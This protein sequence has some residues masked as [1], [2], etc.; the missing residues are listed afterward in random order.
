MA[1]DFI[2][3]S[4]SPGKSTLKISAPGYPPVESEVEVLSGQTTEQTFQ[5]GGG[6]SLSGLVLDAETK[7][8]IEAFEVKVVP[9]DG[10]GKG[11]PIEGT[12]KKNETKKGSFLLSSLPS[13]RVTVEISRAAG[14]SDKEKEMDPESGKI[15]RVPVYSDKSEEVEITAG[16]TTEQTFLLERRGSVAGRVT[17][18]GK[19][20]EGVNVSVEMTDGKTKNS[21]SART[22]ED[23]YYKVGKLNIGKCTILAALQHRCGFKEGTLVEIYDRAQVEVEAG[24]E[25]RQ[26]FDFKGTASI[27][28]SFR[29][30]NRDLFWHVYVLKG[31]SSEYNSV[32]AQDN[33][34]LQAVALNLQNGDRYEIQFLP[35]GTYTLI[36]RCCKEYTGDTPVSEKSQTVT[37]TEGQSL[38][39]NFDLP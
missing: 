25:V 19:V 18:N 13:G 3:A 12:V 23:G 10:D 15:L 34:N 5:L 37:L 8:P 2:V 4:V 7:E 16:K 29:A 39:V 24:K 17:V 38:T 36:A 21:V 9:G 26:D 32:R 27:K 28:G 14:D 35:P 6:G 1:G 33:A 30:S 11:K 20:T 22:K 31:L